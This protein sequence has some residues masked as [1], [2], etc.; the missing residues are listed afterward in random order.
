MI[1]VR[2]EQLAAD[3]RRRLSTSPSEVNAY[4]MAVT[5]GRQDYTDQL[6]KELANDPVEVVVIRDDRFTNPNAILSDFVD[7]V[8]ENRNACAQCVRHEDTRCG[9]VLISRAELSIPQVSSPI[10]LP[11]W[12]P[13]G[14]GTTLSM[15]IEDLTWAAELPLGADEVRLGDL[16][17]MLVDLDRTVLQRLS[18]VRHDD[19]RKANGV[20]EVLKD[21]D[22]A[23]RD[24]LGNALDAREQITT[25]SA[26]RPSI[27]GSSLISRLWR[28]TQIRSAEQL[29]SP[30]ANLADGLDLP[31]EMEKS[32]HE[33]LAFVL[34]RPSGGERIPRERFARNLLL[35]IGATCQLLTAGA[36]SDDYAHYPIPLLRTMSHDLRRALG[37][38]ES[39]IAAQ[40]SGR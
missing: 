17:E 26:F 20:L 11:E 30:A 39:V 3:V 37:D 8:E 24:V 31:G 13:L 34:R 5:E 16:S 29:V 15:R 36:H 7:L 23:I 2:P 19:P 6:R 21:K 40:S 22:E 38:A 10:A 4:W 28:V 32:W 27:R 25:P 18:E 14:G 9:F 1:Q 12:F 35:T 33:S